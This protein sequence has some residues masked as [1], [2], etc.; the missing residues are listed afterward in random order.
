MHLAVAL[1]R[2]EI[3]GVLLQGCRRSLDLMSSARHRSIAGV[4]MRDLALILEASATGF[5][6]RVRDIYRMGIGLSG[7]L[8]DG[9]IDIIT[10]T[11]TMLWHDGMTAFFL[12][13]VL[14]FES[15]LHSTH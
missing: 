1:V 4:R 11:W 10:Y 6:I 8:L 14:G 9:W 15:A 3:D 7:G 13:A 2:L 12:F 5:G